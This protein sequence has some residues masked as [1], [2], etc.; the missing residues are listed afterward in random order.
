MLMK[1]MKCIFLEHELKFKCCANDL[2]QGWVP[3][4][5]FEFD[6]ASY[7][8]VQGYLNLLQPSFPYFP[9]TYTIPGAF[10][11]IRDYQQ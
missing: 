5:L 9:T 8:Q 2:L 3:M 10:M 6:S 4:T 11:T 7:T 1:R